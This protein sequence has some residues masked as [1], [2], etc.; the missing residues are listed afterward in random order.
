MLAK[1]NYFPIFIDFISAI[2]I[3]WYVVGVSQ[4]GVLTYVK[5]LGHKHET[6]EDKSETW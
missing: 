5:L 2:H 3:H 1:Q 4:Q 6:M